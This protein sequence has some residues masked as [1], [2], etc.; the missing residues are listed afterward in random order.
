M[1]LL[2]PGA[3]IFDWIREGPFRSSELIHPLTNKILGEQ[4]L[5]QN[6]SK[7]INGLIGDLRN[8]NED[9]SNYLKEDIFLRT[10]IEYKG[11]NNK[12]ILRSLFSV[13]YDL[14]N[15]NEWEDI[16]EKFESCTKHPHEINKNLN[17]AERKVTSCEQVRD[18]L[19]V[20]LQKTT[21]M[22]ITPVAEKIA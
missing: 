17:S 20:I 4:L 14:R 18:K 6:Q 15:T 1:L 19:I 3:N 22:T 12:Q 5:L 2:K 21:G 9:L 11:W 8:N 16:K 10:N 7:H 13:Q